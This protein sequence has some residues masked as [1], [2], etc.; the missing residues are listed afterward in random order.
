MIVTV[1][2]LANDFDSIFSEWWVKMTDR[3]SK[4]AD[5]IPPN[6]KVADVRIFI[7][8]R[9]PPPQTKMQRFFG[10]YIRNQQIHS[11]TGSIDHL[12]CT[13]GKAS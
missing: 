2:I 10:K 3:N 8:L 13:S 6:T 9:F 5:I 7:L 4:I 1:L 11:Y 12:S